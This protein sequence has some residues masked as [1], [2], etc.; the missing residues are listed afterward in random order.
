MAQK[1]IPKAVI[2]EIAH[3]LHTLQKDGLPISAVYLFGS[4]AKGT[5]KRHSD[6]DV[7]IIS[8][9]FKNADEALHYLWQ[10]RILR[11]TRYAIEPMGMNPEDFATPSPLTNEIRA[12][13]IPV[14]L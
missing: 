13:G 3:Y 8:P 9:A 12:H 5:Q 1:T 2:R 14:A 10:R 7:C 6:I 4:Y 11:D